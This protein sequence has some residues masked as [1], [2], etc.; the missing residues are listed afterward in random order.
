[1]SGRL[2]VFATVM[3]GL[4]L[5]PAESFGQ[6]GTRSGRF[7]RPRR[8]TPE[9]PVPAQPPAEE[10]GEKRFRTSEPPRL[11][12]EQKAKAADERA[13]VEKTEPLPP[14]APVVKTIVHS[15]PRLAL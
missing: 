6:S 9:T 12:E 15:R 1:M 5:L 10:K 3:L 2:R 7:V 8:E 13:V 14:P 11:T 4:A